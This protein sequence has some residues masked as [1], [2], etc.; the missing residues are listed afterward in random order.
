MK[1]QLPNLDKTTYGDSSSWLIVAQNS[2]PHRRLFKD[3]II[4]KSLGQYNMKHVGIMQAQFPYATSRVHQ[5]GS[6]LLACISG[7]GE[8]LMDGNWKRIKANQACILPPHTI[9]AFRA[10]SRQTWKFAWVRYIENPNKKSIANTHSPIQAE[11]D[12]IALLSIIE[13]LR[14]ELENN[15]NESLTSCWIDLLQQQVLKFVRPIEIDSRITNI[16]Q[17]VTDDLSKDW[18]LNALASIGCLS[19]EHFRRLNNK[20]LGRS[21]MQHL[22]Y[23]RIQEARKLLLETNESIES[24][25]NLVGYQNPFSFSNTFKKW[26][27]YRPS[28]LRKSNISSI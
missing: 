9:N 4:C 1:V 17:T 18:T 20:Q 27:G 7:T 13:G 2:D 15:P 10:I 3:A 14:H 25:C 19:E 12:S 24:I 26:L 11:F 5:S 8:I 22:I 28:A 6:F 16:W 23:L 21:P